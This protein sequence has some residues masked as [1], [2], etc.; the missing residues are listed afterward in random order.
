MTKM[1]MGTQEVDCA[2]CFRPIRDRFILKVLD[3]PWHPA[4]V[5][6]ALCQKLLDEKCF[7]REGKMYCRDDF[8]RYDY[9][10]RRLFMLLF[11][12]DFEQNSLVSSEPRYL[13]I[14]NNVSFLQA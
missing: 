1:T 10:F 14:D 9:F 4:C 6:C 8:Y 7:Y 2:A 3:K 5:R 13:K 11:G 12:L